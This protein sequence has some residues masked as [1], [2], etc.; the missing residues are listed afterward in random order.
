MKNAKKIDRVWVNDKV[1]DDVG[2][3]LIQALKLE[4][5]P[6]TPERAPL[7]ETS[8][9]YKTPAG[10]ARVILEAMDLNYERLTQEITR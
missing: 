8:M 5:L 1:A 6:N 9:G 4:R 7:F 10:V 2:R 3:R